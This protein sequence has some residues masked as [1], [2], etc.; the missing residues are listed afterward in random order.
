MA[1]SIGSIL[2]EQNG[3]GPGF[4]FLRLGL[5]IA[6]LVA[7]CSAIGQTRGIGPEIWNAILQLFGQA[8]VPAQ[9]AGAAATASGQVQSAIPWGKP[10]PVSHV[11]MFFALS[12]FLVSGSAARTRQLMPFLA[13]RFFRIF[14]A[15]CV[16]VVLSAVLIG[17][18]FSSLAPADYFFDR[19]FFTY[20]GNIFGFIQFHLP[21]VLFDSGD[22]PTV[23]ANLWTLPAEFYSYLLLAVLIVTGIAFNRKAYTIVFSISA[24]A[25][26]TANSFFGYNATPFKLAGDINVYCFAVGVLF[27]LW[28]D[29]IPYNPWLFLACVVI[30]YGLI[31][32][33]HAIFIYPL[34]L[35]YV[36]V[37]LGTTNF[38]KIRVLQSGD[39]SYGIYLYGYPITQVL[40]TVFPELRHNFFG[41]VAAT[42]VCTGFF[43]YLSWHLIEKR[44]LGLRKRFSAKSAEI[45]QKLHPS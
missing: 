20:F 10:L 21:G 29:R 40:V 27:F 34:L 9:I 28:R 39:Y 23:N 5:S 19:Q 30:S 37:Y 13:L 15:L 26:I 6:I 31:F 32:S 42:I 17:V 33:A 44:F 18:L 7:H 14:P 11:P 43:A 41:L 1:K 12:G 16:E 24:I 25:L 38:P 36:T 35:A 2:D 22:P 4:D 45:T 3:I 8:Q